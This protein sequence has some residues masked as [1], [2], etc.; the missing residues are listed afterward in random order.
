ME[1]LLY[2]NV[3]EALLLLTHRHFGLLSVRN[4][5]KRKFTEDFTREAG[6]PLAIFFARSDFISLSLSFQLKPYRTINW[7]CTKERDRLIARK[8][9]LVE[10][11]TA[12][13]GNDRR[14]Y[15][16]HTEENQNLLR[17]RLHYTG[18]IFIPD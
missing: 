16:R 18:L 6:F 13:T 14:R 9:S 2:S 5:S 7:V 1:M 3:R 11:S 15:Q 12:I 10:K 8:N 4:H 17:P